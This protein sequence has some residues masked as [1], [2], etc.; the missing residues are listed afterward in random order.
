MEK[1]EKIKNDRIREI[2]KV[3]PNH[4]SRDMIQIGLWEMVGGITL[5][6]TGIIQTS[7]DPRG[8]HCR[9]LHHLQFNKNRGPCMYCKVVLG[10]REKNKYELSKMS[11]IFLF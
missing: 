8:S 3:F 7:F 11:F 4:Q 1:E 2:R 6:N 9:A 5:M 10:E